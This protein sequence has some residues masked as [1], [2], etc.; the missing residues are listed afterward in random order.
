MMLSNPMKAF[1]GEQS[2]DG[3]VLLGQTVV[4]KHFDERGK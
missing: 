1:C 2:H 3:W 4:K